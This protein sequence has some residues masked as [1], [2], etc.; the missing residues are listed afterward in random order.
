MD[1][2]TIG[3]ELADLSVKKGVKSHQLNRLYEVLKTRDLKNF[4]AYVSRQIGRGMLNYEVG[5]KIL[6]LLKEF[7]NRED[8]IKIHTFLLSFY[9]YFKVKPMYE[10]KEKIEKIVEEECSKAGV[11]FR[12]ADIETRKEKFIINIKVSGYVNKKDFSF[13]LK[14][15][16]KNKVPELKEVIF[17]VWVN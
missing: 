5:E 4:E 1:T 16:L 14:G 17:Q 15:V 12:D 2:Y 6:D 3:K 9:P 13:K 8:V 11:K 10:N 7:D